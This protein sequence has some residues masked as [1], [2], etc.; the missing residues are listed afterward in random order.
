[1]KILITGAAGFIGMHLA[2]SF[3]Q[4]KNNIVIGVDNINNYYDVKIKLE[5]I[6]ILKKYNNFFFTKSDLNNVKKIDNLFKK[7]NPTIVINL[8]AQAGVRYSILNPDTYLKSNI[9]GFHNILKNAVKYKVK[10]LLFASTS[11]VYGANQTKLNREKDYTET[12]LSVYAA[13][14]KTN[15]NLAHVYSYLYKIKTTGLRFF[16][17]YGPLGRPDM[18]LFKFVKNILNKKTIEIYNNGNMQRSFTYIDDITEAI[19]KLSKDKKPHPNSNGIPFN[20]FNIGNNKS[21]RLS[22]FVK[23]IENSLK[24]KAKKKFLP[25]QKG[26]VKATCADT[27][28]LFDLIGYS[29]KTSVEYGVKKFI[30]W[31]KIFYSIK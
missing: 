15:E 27:S 22:K 1:M 16:T 3:L 31:Y 11:S 9:N 7:Y 4:N 23:I 29:P 20:I 2:H 24:M 18:A 12:P 17:V 25:I 28:K 6:R 5:R 21:M 26:D 30:E 8:A 10:H 13:T 14:K 19:V